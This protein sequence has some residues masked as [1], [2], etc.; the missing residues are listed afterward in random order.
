M[1]K[2]TI[3]CI[4][5]T[6]FSA[7]NQP[8][9]NKFPDTFAGRALFS[10]WTYPPMER[11]ENLTTLLNQISGTW[12]WQSTG[13]NWGT[14]ENSKKGILERKVVINTDGEIVFYENGS[15][16]FADNY[17]LKQQPE[18]FHDKILMDLASSNQCY[19]VY[20]Q[21]STLILSEPNCD[22]GCLTHKYVRNVKAK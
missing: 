19:S 8:R 1:K 6:V 9:D 10:N 5:L 12:I 17:T 16:S 3:I 21:K 13:T 15:I 2:R 7:C 22:C 14:N 4:A 18:S 20:L 11:I